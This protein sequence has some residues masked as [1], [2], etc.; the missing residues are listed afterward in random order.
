MLAVHSSSVD[1]WRWRL[2]GRG[3]GPAAGG[4]GGRDGVPRRE[5][6][7]E[8]VDAPRYPPPPSYCS[9]YHSP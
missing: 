3:D 9:P 7:G 4:G 6:G 2:G 5:G 8:A 1:L